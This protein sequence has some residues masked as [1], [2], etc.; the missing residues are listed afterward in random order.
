MG[1]KEKATGTDGRRKKGKQP[2]IIN[3]W[4]CSRRIRSGGFEIS[5]T[6][7]AIVIS[8]DARQQQASGLRLWVDSVPDDNEKER[9]DS[10]SEVHLLAVLEPR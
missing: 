10:D 8:L 4:A 1:A 6:T 5:T 2:A 3:H 7:F 9:R